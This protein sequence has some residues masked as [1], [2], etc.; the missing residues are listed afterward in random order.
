MALWFRVGGA[1]LFRVHK[2]QASKMQRVLKLRYRPERDGKD[3][4]LLI[5]SCYVACAHVRGFPSVSAS[6]KRNPKIE[7]SG[8]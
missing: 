5:D 4:H 2:R 7:G 8:F 1:G 6:F 3:G